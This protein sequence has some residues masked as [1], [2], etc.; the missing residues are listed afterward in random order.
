MTEREIRE[1]RAEANELMSVYTR[2]AKDSAASKQD[3]KKACDAVILKLLEH[4][5]LQEQY[6]SQLILN[7]DNWR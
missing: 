6:I 3:L 2:T 5:D 7:D 1:A 4:A